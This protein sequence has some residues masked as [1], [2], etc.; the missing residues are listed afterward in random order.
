MPWCFRGARS[1][2]LANSWCRRIR[3]FPNIWNHNLH[4]SWLHRT[5]EFQPTPPI[6]QVTVQGGELL[7]PGEVASPS[8]WRT[9]LQEWEEQQEVHFATTQALLTEFRMEVTALVEARRA[10]A[11]ASAAAA[12]SSCGAGLAIATYVERTSYP[13]DDA[14]GLH[15]GTI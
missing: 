15:S 1:N 3:L 13:N 6:A 12:P 8:G 9:T 7:G 4:Q 10:G 2:G 14:G 11:S 5:L